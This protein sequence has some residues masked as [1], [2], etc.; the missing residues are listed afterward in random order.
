MKFEE[1]HPLAPLATQLQDPYGGS[2]VL[3]NKFTVAPE[4]RDALVARGPTT[5]RTL[6]SSQVSCPPSC[7][8][9][10]ARAPCS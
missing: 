8:E 2:V 9:G 7:T 4:D 5:Q 1:M 10:S 6:S 3:I